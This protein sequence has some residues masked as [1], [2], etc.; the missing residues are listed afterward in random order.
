MSLTPTPTVTPSSTPLICGSGVTSGSYYYTDCCGNLVTGRDSGNTV[1]LDYTKPYNGIKILNVPAT[2]VCLTPTTT[3]TPTVTPTNTATPKV[4]PTPTITPT[5]TVTASPTPSNSPVYNLKNE[6]DVFTLFDMG[7][8]CNPIKLPSGPNSFDGI[9]SLKVTGGTS[10]YSFYWAGGQRVQTLVGLPPGSYEVIVVDYYGD[11]TAN[12]ICSLF[13][14]S[15][16]PTPTVTSTPTVTPSPVWPNLCLI[17]SNEQATYGPYQFTPSG[18]RNGKPS[19]SC[20]P[21]QVIWTG[22]RWEVTGWNNTQGIP[23]STNTTNIPDSSWTI[24]GGAVA[25]VSMLQGTCPQYLP[26]QV[27]TRAINNTCNQTTN[28]DGSITVTARN[29]VPPYFYSIDNG[30]TYQNS[31]FFNGLCPNTYTVI[32][33]DSNNSSQTNSVTVGYNSNPITYLSGIEVDEIISVG[34]NT[35]IANWR[36]KITPP[37]PIGVTITLNVDLSVVKYIN[38]PGTGTISDVDYV[39]LNNIPK[40]PTTTGTNSSVINRANCSPYTTTAITNSTTYQVTVGNGDVLS[41]TSTSLLSIG[42]GQG[43]IGPNGCTTTLVQSILVATSS[44][45]INGCVCCEV[46]DIDEPQ[47]IVDHTYAYSNI[48]EPPVLPNTGKIVNV[49]N[50][51]VAPAVI[52]YTN[53]YTGVET[54]MTLPKGRTSELCVKC[55]TPTPVCVSCQRYNNNTFATLEIDYQSCEG[56]WYYN[57]LIPAS[58]SVCIVPETG[59]G[60]DWGSMTYSADCGTFCQPTSAIVLLSGGPLQSVVESECDTCGGIVAV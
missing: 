58:Q 37:L 60:I 28:C 43:V 27:Y 13:A 19:W 14:P 18:N 39:Y 1:S 24:A 30:V 41:G 16:T 47:G 5:T 55:P 25:Q 45:V 50:G 17:V 33:R 20:S 32:T 38:G 11:Y 4:T 12:T 26:L 36:L 42:S 6:C 48:I 23:V 57:E 56:T 7:V 35:K 59:G 2:T 22:T 31:P 52:S 10:P 15:S 49:T 29:G 34:T 51:G 53:A 44:P 3:P 54:V 40:T 8:R 21:Y 9:L 46:R